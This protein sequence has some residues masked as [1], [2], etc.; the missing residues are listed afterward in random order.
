MRKYKIKEAYDFYKKFIYNE[1]HQGLLEKYK[2]RVAGSIPSIDWELF[3]AILTE[4]IGK[5]GYGS[6]LEHHEIKSS[7]VGASF[8]YQYHLHGGGTKLKEDMLVAHIFVSYS[9]DYKN[10]EVRVVDGKELKEIFTSWLPGWKAN[11]EGPNRRQRYR[12]SISYG[13]VCRDGTIIMKVKDGKLITA[14]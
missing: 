9:S 7:I 11:Y 2:L 14:K 1:E 12:K 4:D 5:H 3:G 10:L 8:E 6:D 13:R